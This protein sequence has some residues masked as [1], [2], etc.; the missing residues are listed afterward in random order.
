[1]ATEG[2][3]LVHAGVDG[4]EGQAAADGFCFSSSMERFDESD[5]SSLSAM[6]DEELDQAITERRRRKNK[7]RIMILVLMGDWFLD[8]MILDALGFSLEGQ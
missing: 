2:G 3:V 4:R 8:L 7:P 6:K 5:R 1:M